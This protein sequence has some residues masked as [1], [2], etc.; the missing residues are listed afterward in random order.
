MFPIF[1]I[2][3]SLNSFEIINK[4]KAMLFFGLNNITH[5]ENN[6]S[7]EL[8][9]RILV[10]ANIFFIL[11]YKNPRKMFGFSKYRKNCQLINKSKRHGYDNRLSSIS[12]RKSTS[13]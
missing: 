8:L 9:D 12:S 4:P 7:I 3:L 10:I 1:T 11:G 13:S 6:S 5:K 2:H